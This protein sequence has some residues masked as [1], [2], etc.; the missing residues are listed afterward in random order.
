MYQPMIRLN[1]GDSQNHVFHLQKMSEQ[2]QV[3]AYSDK[4]KKTN[5][6]PSESLFWI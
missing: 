5:Y 4:I 3:V 1:R 6:A 2:I